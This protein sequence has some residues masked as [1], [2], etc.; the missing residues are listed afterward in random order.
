[1]AEHVIPKAREKAPIER[2][3]GRD[4]YAV[5]AF[6]EIVDR[7]LHATA[8]GALRVGSISKVRHSERVSADLQNRHGNPEFV[9]CT[10]TNRVKSTPTAR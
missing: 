1:M 3:G 8:A 7:S 5:M 2:V 4:S 9:P 6:A 10:P